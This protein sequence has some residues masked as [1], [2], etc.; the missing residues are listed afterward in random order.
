M[1]IEDLYLVPSEDLIDDEGVPSSCVLTRNSTQS[2]SSMLRNSPFYGRE[3]SK[4]ST[5][6]QTDIDDELRRGA[7]KPVVAVYPSTESVAVQTPLVPAVGATAEGMEALRLDE[8]VVLE[9]VGSLIDP[10]RRPNRRGNGHRAAGN[11]FP[12]D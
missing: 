11:H 3:A 7:P 6:F 9:E 8:A 10:S 2:H 4:R 1:A 5:A 12:I